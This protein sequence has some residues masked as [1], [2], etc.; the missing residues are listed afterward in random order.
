MAVCYRHPSRETN[1]AC[2]NCGRAIC[3]DCMTSTPVGMRCPEC[4]SQR[5]R[6]HRAPAGMAGGDTPATYAF[7]GLCVIAFIAQV[8]SGGEITRG[9]GEVGVDGGVLGY[10]IDAGRNQIG[11][12]A[13]EWYRVLA[14]GFLHSGV[15]HLGLNMLALYFLGQLLEPAI[16]TARFV[17][18]FFLSLLGGS[19][20]ALALSPDQLTVGASGAVF[21]LMA[22]SFL[23]A[24]SRGMNDVASQI[25]VYVVINL[26]ITVS[27]P[28]ISLGGHVGGLI[29]GGLIIMLLSTVRKGRGRGGQPLEF[30]AMGVVAAALVVASVLVANS[31][32]PAGFG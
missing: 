13:G 18:V 26:V 24:R 29:T 7:I 3:P 16:G 30:A 5:T 11:V 19:L 14:G 15:L 4:A 27:I 10:G 12:A 22:A 17:G 31:S 8:G 23:E 2:S 28:N 20:G 25:G 32:A 9:I 1:V 6:V 21:G